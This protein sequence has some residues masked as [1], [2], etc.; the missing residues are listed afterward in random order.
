MSSTRYI[1]MDAAAKTVGKFGKYRRC[2]VVEV[3]ADFDGTPAMISERA[4]GVV[5]IVQIWERRS[6]GK[7]PRSAFARAMAEAAALAA[8][9]N[10]I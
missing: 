2:A 7:T 1:V 6:V 9:M 4:K 5:S 3:A 10:A 8:E